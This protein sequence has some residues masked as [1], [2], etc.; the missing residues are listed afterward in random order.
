MIADDAAAETEQIL[1]SDEGEA[2]AESK[3]GRKQMKLD[4]KEQKKREK[5]AAKLQRKA[6]KCANKYR[7]H[8]STKYL[9]LGDLLFC[10]FLILNIYLLSDKLS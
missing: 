10:I 8:H 5:E 7:K 9:A 2:Y 6:D 1:Y 4:I 3:M